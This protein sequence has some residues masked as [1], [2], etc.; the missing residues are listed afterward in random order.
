MLSDEAIYVRARLAFLAG[1]TGLA[2]LKLPFPSGGG[3]SMFVAL[4]LMIGATSAVLVAGER[5][6]NV[7]ER[8]R[9]VVVP[10]LLTVLGMTYLLHELEDGFFPIVV[11]LAI[12]YALILP[13]KQAMMVSLATM[14]AYVVGHLAAHAMS[15]PQWALFLLNAAS[16]PLLALMVATSVE[17]RRQ[18]EEQVKQ[19]VADREEALDDVQRRVA[20]LQAVSEIT[21][22]IHSSLDFERVG[23]VVL[24]ILSKLIDLETCCLFVVDKDRSETLFSASIGMEVPSAARAHGHFDYGA[25]DS[26]FSCLSLFD[27]GDMI[28]LFCATA[29]DT[30]RLNDDDRLVLGAIASELVVA[31]ENSRLYKLTKTLA[32]TDE[33]TGIANY[34]SLQNRLEDEVERSK[35]FGKKLSLLMLDV[36]DFKAFNDRYGHV[37]GDVALADIA[38]ALQS[39]VRDVDLVARYGGEEFSIV[40]PET[41]AAGAFV[42]AEKVR[43]AVSESVLRGPEGEKCTAVTVSIGLATYPTHA[44]DREGLLREADDALYQ[45][46]CGGKNRVRSASNSAS[47]KT[48]ETMEA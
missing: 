39:A 44:H 30:Q 2:F 16:V 14:V 15:V 10:D 7:R 25:L 27:H 9:W 46:K 38:R 23:P 48:Q 35:R 32:V 18:Q 22:V 21:E 20:E 36:D 45:A 41:D 1:F 12:A 33:L 47:E 3:R 6:G 17:H 29:E 37:A 26:H 31:V 43:E 28:V 5:A 40:L 4:L 8:M 11:L 19:A 24:R 34:R 13:R 42:A